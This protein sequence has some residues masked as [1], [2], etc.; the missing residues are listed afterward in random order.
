[1]DFGGEDDGDE[2]EEMSGWRWW[3]KDGE[4]DVGDRDGVYTRGESRTRMSRR[5]VARLG[6]LSPRL[7]RQWALRM[8]LWVLLLCSKRMRGT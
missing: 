6:S 2:V 7:R 4:R 5:V 1:M 3:V 8:R